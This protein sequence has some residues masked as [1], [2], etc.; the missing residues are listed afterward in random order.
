MRVANI[1]AIFGTR[2]EAIKM[3]PLILTLQKRSNF[4]VS[5]TVTAQHRELLDQVLE[6]FALEADYD[7]DIMEKKQNLTQIT[8]KALAGLEKVLSDFK[9]DLILVH[10]DTTTTFA[11][12]LAAFY[13]KIPVGHVEA[14]LRTYDFYQPYPEEI[15]RH[16]TA[17]LATY[18]FAP[19]KTA[20]QNLLGENIAKE[21][22]IITGNTVIDALFHILK[23]P[24]SFTDDRLKDLKAG[25]TI[26]MTAH[27]RENWG[28]PLRQV[29]QALKRLIEEMENLQLVFPMHPN[30]VLRQDLLPILGNH[31]RIILTEPLSYLQFAHLMNKVDLILTDSGGIQEEAPALGKPV[32]VIR[33][34]TERPE[35]VVGKTVKVIGCAEARVFAEVKSLLTNQKKYQEMSQA[36]NPYGDGQA[37]ER[38]CEFLLREF[39]FS[40]S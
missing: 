24:C 33:E 12:A 8:I 6:L 35:G 18:H 37:S 14:G 11:A 29:A 19:T 39:N 4:K 10:G 13:Q 30:H 27:R 17:K 38:I 32:L 2:P 5:I 16:L 21:K 26:L 22:I 20:Y 9:P 40:R 1:M 28:K 7:L 34:K 3:A 25:P 23:N 36:K 15:N 31:P